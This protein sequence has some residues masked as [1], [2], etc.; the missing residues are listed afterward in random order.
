MEYIEGV[1]VLDSITEQP[2]GC[3]TED[4]AKELFI[5]IMEGV[6]YLHSMN[7]AH[8]DIKPQ[9]LLVTKEKKVYIMDFNVSFKNNNMGQPFKMMT[10]T[11]TVT[12]SAPEIFIQKVYDEKVD[13]WS[14]GIVLHM[15]L[16]GQVPF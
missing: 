9:N 3:Y 14:A 1:E 2:H 7:I 15:M 8:R 16:C 10:K 4:D 12:F 11:G 13:I 6:E 5:Q